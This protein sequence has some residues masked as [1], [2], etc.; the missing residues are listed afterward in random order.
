MPRVQDALGSVLQA[1]SRIHGVLEGHMARDAAYTFMNLGIE[2]ERADISLRILGALLPVLSVNGW[3]RT[4]DDVRWA[5]LLSALGVLAM[6]RRKHHHQTELPILL[7]FL[8]VDRASP[9]SL[10]HC[11]RQIEDQLGSLP[12][13]GRVRAAVSAAT[14]RAFALSHATLAEVPR[15]IDEAL[16]ALASLHGALSSCY[17]PVVAPSAS[18]LS[19][20]LAASAGSL[21]PVEYVG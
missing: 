8:L 6:Y 15:L 19:E 1:G 4:F 18:P 11:L 9:R 3:E 13:A 21:D 5:G 20:R 7:D 2:L 17:F 16:A 14:T 12:R 10:A